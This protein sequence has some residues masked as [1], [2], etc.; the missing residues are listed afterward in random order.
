GLATGA[1]IVSAYVERIKDPV[2]ALAWV[3][4]SVGVS[5]LL[6]S[7]LIDR[8][9]FWL[10]EAAQGPGVTMDSIYVTNF[11]IAAAIT[12]PPT[13]A[14]GAV[15]P[16]VVRIL[17]PKGDSEAGAVVG[18]AYALNT[19]GAIIG[20]FAGGFIILPLLGVEWGLMSTA[21]LSIGLGVGLAWVAGTQVPRFVIAGALALTFV[22]AM[23]RWDVRR[24][25]AGVFRMYLA[26]SVFSDGWE[27]YGEVVYH[28]DG[29]VTTVTVEQQED[30][31][32]VSLKVNGKVDAS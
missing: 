13:L 30:K 5:A 11:F 25:T 16:L 2:R 19:L 3:E 15:M 14:L 28:R 1:A 22:L 21:M 23:P 7:L 24:W 9:P 27:P 6:A 29:V 12:F 17:A 4:V 26:R 18:R 8:V 31:V 20:S 10:L 32:G